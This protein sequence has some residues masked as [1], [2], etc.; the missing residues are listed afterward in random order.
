MEFSYN[1]GII[2]GFIALLL[3]LLPVIFKHLKLIIR[4]AQM[5]IYVLHL[6][7]SKDGPSKYNFKIME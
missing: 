3:F 6:Y 7:Y 5:E 4:Y 2:L 1:L